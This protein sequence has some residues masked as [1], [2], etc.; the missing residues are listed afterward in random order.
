MLPLNYLVIIHDQYMLGLHQG[1]W[2]EQCMAHPV[3]S[4]ASAILQQ[5]LVIQDTA[6]EEK[7]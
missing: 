6:V 1:T 4:D 3:S 2:S 7:G 5:M